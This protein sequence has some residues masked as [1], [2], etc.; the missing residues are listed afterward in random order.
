[1]TGIIVLAAGESKRFGTPKQLAVLHGKPLLRRAVEAA[2][3][4]RLGPVTVVLGA[5]DQPCRALLAGLEVTI[6]HN[7]GWRSGMG[8]SIASGMRSFDGL[9]LDGVV[10]SLA[11]QAGVTAEHLRWLEAASAGK[12]IVASRYG[13]QLG[14]PAW[15]SAEKFEELLKLDG[16]KGAK[17]LIAREP[18]AHGVEMPAAAFDVDTP[19]DLIGKSA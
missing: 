19:E 5:T 13:G 4:A 6:V 9:E 7:P 15:F 17:L 14:A 1:M 11:D 3:E 12:P 8:S 16:E 18:A 10:I 2:L